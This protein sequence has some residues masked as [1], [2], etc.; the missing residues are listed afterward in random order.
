MRG[1]PQRWK[2]R[3]PIQEEDLV[4][5]S[6]DSAP[7]PAREPAVD[8]AVLADWRKHTLWFVVPRYDRDNR[9]FTDQAALSL[10]EVERLAGRETF[11]RLAQE[12][13]ERSPFGGYVTQYGSTPISLSRTV[14]LLGPDGW[15][16]VRQLIYPAVGE[17]IGRT[18]SP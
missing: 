6:L 12:L 10:A 11:W 13:E 15:A 18:L 9:P 7:E 5:D 4:R 3:G 2:R 8:E 17:S 14:E 16:A 1:G